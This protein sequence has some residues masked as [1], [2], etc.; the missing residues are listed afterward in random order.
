MG[1]DGSLNGSGTTYASWTIRKQPKF[2]DVVTYTGTGATFKTISHSLGS[3]P[4]CI[5]VK[6]TNNTSNWWVRHRSQTNIGR[7]NLTNAF[8]QNSNIITN[9]TS[10]TFDV[11]VPAGGANT[12][13]DSYVAYLFAHDA[14]GFGLTGTDN[15]ISC[16]SYT[17]SVGST[18]T[19]GYEPQYLLLKRTDSTSGWF[20]FD[21]MRGLSDS[22]GA[23]LYANTA[24]AEVDAGQVFLPQ[25]T[26]FKQQQGLFGAGANVI[27]IAIRRGPMKV[28]TSGTSVFQPVAR[29]GTGSTATVS[30]SLSYVDLAL[31]SARTGS[32]V[33]MFFDRLRGATRFVFSSGTNAE[34]TDTNTLTSFSLQNGVTLGSDAGGYGINVSGT[35]AINWLFRRAPGFMDVC[36]YTGTGANTTFNHNLQ[37]VPEMIICKRRSAASNWSVYHSSLTATKVIQLD[38]TGAATTNSTYWNNTSPT[39]TNFALG[40][41]SD[42]NGSASTYLAYLFATCAGVSKVGSYTGTGTTL[43]IDCG[44]A[45]GARFVLI[46]CSSSTGD[47]YVWDSARG[48]VSGN[49]PYLLLNST[50]TEVTNTDYVDTYSAGFE[51]SSTA[52]AAINASGGTFIYLAIA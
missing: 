36:C 40:N 50:A 26:G 27:Y 7:L 12:N 9:L 29:T 38:F 32:V 24:G 28:P 19:L 37:V 46:K 30:T 17:E 14:G 41:S 43:Q 10:T 3:V 49:D 23:Y 45:A 13:G 1:S 2:F 34:I 44:F 6:K 33:Q 39:S 15:V 22:T 47:W 31:L 25:P 8:D 35:T 51:I 21:T 4:G 48:I 42:V 52:P 16:G 5:I 18:V 20:V 11:G